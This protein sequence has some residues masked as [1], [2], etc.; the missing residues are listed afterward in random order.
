M[1]RTLFPFLVICSFSVSI[2]IGFDFGP[3]GTHQPLES[4]CAPISDAGRPGSCEYFLCEYNAALDVWVSRI[5]EPIEG[6]QYF[7]ES[8][9]EMSPFNVRDQICAYDVYY[10]AEGCHGEPVGGDSIYIQSCHDGQ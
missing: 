1:K 7:P 9:C 6:C 8:F 10:D 3:G 2:A 5:A 4:K